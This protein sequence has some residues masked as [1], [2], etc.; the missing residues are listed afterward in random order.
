MGRIVGKV[1]CVW[2]IEFWSD[3]RRC[4]RVSDSY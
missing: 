4:S 2:R 3:G 1:R